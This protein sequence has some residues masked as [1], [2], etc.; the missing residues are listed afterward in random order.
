MKETDGPHIA[1][2][3]LAA[4]EP[5]L[6]L[7]E[8]GSQLAFA[9]VDPEVQARVKVLTLDSLASALT[10]W[11][12]N[13]T[14][15]VAESAVKVFGPGNSAVIGGGTAAMAAATMINGYLITAR[16]L[17]DVHRPTLCHVT[18]VVVPAVLAA[19]FDAQVDGSTLLAGL[20]AGMES[21]VRIGL[22]LNY[23]EFRSRGWH[24]PG[25]AGPLAAALGVARVMG[26]DRALSA[27]AMGIAAEHA[28]GTFAVF[29]TPS[30]KYN[31]SRASVAGLISA[32]MARR[33]FGA[34][35][36]ILTANDGGLLST[37]SDGGTPE[38]ITA[39]LGERWE[40]T[41]ITTRLWPAGAGLQ[42]VIAMLMASDAPTP[43]EVE[44][45]TVRL[46]PANFGMHADM[47][48]ETPFHAQLSARYIVA[49]ALHD[50]RCW[51]DQYLP[52]RLEDPAL[53]AFASNQVEVLEDPDMSDGGATVFVTTSSGDS[54]SRHRDFPIGHPRDP[55]SWEQTAQKLLDAHSGR[56]TRGPVTEIVE[57]VASL[58]K[59]T[60]VRQLA[61]LLGSS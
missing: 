16:S 55:A 25:V 1:E 26:L 7:A 13:E 49:V 21:N 20:T 42:A 48:W 57:M 30:I 61:E 19:A 60:N 33:G 58:E 36:N 41:E 37:Y 59:V 38:R 43:A 54:W 8:F 24:T 35:E 10:G 53:S 51:L 11:G 50:R 52:A 47:G 6:A 29:G 32:E 28:S 56:P 31:Q 45:V 2:P 46:S 15:I 3:T 27:R 4:T 44:K 12:S 40:L 22:G 23:Q 39:D 14:E 5:T 18:P 9:Q 34:P 17:C